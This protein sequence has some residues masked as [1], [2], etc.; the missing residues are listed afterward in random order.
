MFLRTS[1]IILTR[2]FHQVEPRGGW[3]TGPVC[4]KAVSLQL[5]SVSS[6]SIPPST[7]SF[8]CS[9]W[10][11][12]VEAAASQPTARRWGDGDFRKLEL[13]N[14]KNRLLPDR[15]AP[16]ATLPRRLLLC[17][18]LSL[19][20]V[21][22]PRRHLQSR[23]Q[24]NFPAKDRYGIRNM[25]YS[26]ELVEWLVTLIPQAH[27]LFTFLNLIIMYMTCFSWLLAWI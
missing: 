19:V 8:P 10:L 13:R 24:Y 9:S 27:S 17:R 5:S 1:C 11:S 16:P 26:T 4:H 25:C 3:S 15:S 12:W 14:Q 20:T 23:S 2:M 7:G 21:V 22:V 18:V 6:S